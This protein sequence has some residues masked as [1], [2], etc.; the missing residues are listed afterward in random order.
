M[1]DGTRA[2]CIKDGIVWEIDFANSMKW[3]EAIGQSIHYAIQKQFRPGIVLITETKASCRYAY[4]ADQAVKNYLVRVNGDWL[5]PKLVTVGP[6]KCY[7]TISGG[8]N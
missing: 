1:P 6:Y 3:Y 8:V 2:D 4:R 7:T 5:T